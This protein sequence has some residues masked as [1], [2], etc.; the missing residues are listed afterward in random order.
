MNS[1]TFETDV[2][3][4][5][6]GASGI[7]AAIG[8]ARAG[9]RVALVEEDYAV[10]GATTD[11]Y[12]D[13][14]CGGPMCG[15]MKEADELLRKNYKL[16]EKHQRFFL[17]SAFVRVFTDLLERENKLAVFTGAKATDVILEGDRIAGVK[18]NDGFEIKSKVTI[19]ATGSGALAL[20]AGCESR[21]GTDSQSDF[22]EQ[23]AP[24]K[25]SS[26]VQQCTWMYLSQQ[27]DQDKEP[28]D[29][30]KL[31]HVNIGVMTNGAGFFHKSPEEA[32]RLKPQLFL[33]WGCVVECSDTRDPIAIGKA[34]Q[35]ALK[36]M[37][38]DHALLKENG[39]AVYLAPKI[40]I[41]EQSRIVCDHMITLQDLCSGKLPEDTIAVGN[42]GID[43][44]GGKKELWGGSKEKPVTVKGYGI[45]Y[46]AIL[47]QGIE[48]LLVVGKAIGGTHIAMSAYRV[49]PIVASIGQ[50]GGVAAA[51]AAER[52]S[53]PRNI[54]PSEIREILKKDGQGVMLDFESP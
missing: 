5:G 51:L 37:E 45:P 46:G 9:A 53:H 42:Y 33:H 44:W 48:G 31:E 10:G 12:V 38:R 29:M 39:Y 32:M 20:M 47:P 16:G 25:D 23:L 43:I 1:R 30:T 40:G 49:M 6:G 15:V 19:D 18:I 27:L 7:P 41:R 22:G 21:Y 26:Q 54:D 36:A 14:L 11:F 28:F 4:V 24:E 8:A 50:A 35:Q 52:G 3:V 13:M 17:P 34:Q 2:L